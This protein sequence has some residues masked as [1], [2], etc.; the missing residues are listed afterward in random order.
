MPWTFSPFVLP[1]FL[2]G[3]LSAA[4]FALSWPHRR[5]PGVWAFLLA[6]FA[7]TMWSIPYGIEIGFHSLKTKVTWINIEYLGITTVP[8]G[9][10]GFAL[11]YTTNGRL[12]TRKQMGAL[13]AFAALTWVLC[14]TDPYHH[15]MRHAVTPDTLG[16]Q[17]HITIHYG[18]WFW[19]STS[20]SYIL[21]FTGTVVL[22][23]AIP[24]MSDLYRRQKVSLLTAALFPWTANLLYLARISPFDRYDLT[25]VTFSITAAVCGW[26][27]FRYSLF[28]L[29]PVARDTVIEEM[30]DGVLVLD[31][32]GR[33]VDTNRSATLILGT[34]RQRAL[35]Q[36]PN[37]VAPEYT[38][39]LAPDADPI[40]SVEEISIRRKGH[41]VHYEVHTSPLRDRAGRALGSVVTIHDVS[42]RRAAEIEREA[43]ITELRKTVDEVRQL[44]GLLPICAS[45]KK[46]R[47][48]AGYWQQLEDYI[49]DHS[50]A[51]FTHGL[52]P[53]CLE[54]LESAYVR[55]QGAE[56]P[57][58]DAQDDQSLA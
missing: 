10:F 56:S 39:M 21:L 49:A 8:I 24:R 34:T 43:L 11:G 36:H 51:R 57:D 54:K 52:C 30:A 2:S 32:A 1:L 16:G 35:G 26:A 9:W 4:V 22:L 15:L 33:I 23:R 25:P 40:L 13:L 50:E 3:L 7:I 37:D 20:V 38:D 53:D 28:D 12:P 29:V 6:L 55:E 42:E 48:D 17:P 45:C 18:P 14:W 47:D 5:T 27:L 46:I 58:G 44:G 31:Q 41:D 19:L